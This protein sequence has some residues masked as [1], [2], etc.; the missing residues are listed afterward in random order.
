MKTVDGLIN[1]GKLFLFQ[2][3]TK[4]YSEKS[5]GKKNLHTMYWEAAF[6]P[7]NIKDV[8]VKINGEAE[9]FFRHKSRELKVVTHRAGSPLVNRTDKD[10]KPI[11]SEIYYELFRFKTGQKKYDDLSPEVRSYIDKAVVSEAKYDI[12]KDRRYTEDRMFFHIPLTFNFKASGR[13]NIND[14]AIRYYL[15]NPDVHIMGIDRG[16]RN[17]IYYSIIDRDGKIVRDENGKCLQGNFNIINGIDYHQKLDIRQK[18]RQESRRNWKVVEKIKDLKEGYISLVVHEIAEM[19]VKY[20]AV[21]VMED[22]NFGFKRGRFKFEKQVYQKFEQML[23]DKLNYLVFKEAGLN[24]IGGVMKAYQFTDKFDSFQK[25]GKQSGILF[26]VPASYTSKIDP[27]TGFTDLFNMA[28]ITSGKTR[29]DFVSKMESVVYNPVDNGFDITFDYRDFLTTQTDHRNKWT[30]STRGTRIKYDSKEKK[31]YVVDPTAELCES[32][33]KAGIIYDAEADILQKILKSNDQGL[34][35][36][37]FYSFKNS[38]I[39]IRNMSKFLMCLFKTIY[40]NRYCRQF[41]FL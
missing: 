14:M 17:L 12:V 36:T 31:H 27:M 10:G 38:F 19:I 3:Y 28:S 15:D 7:E 11:P 30:V 16:E 20:N 2:L 24:D 32:L 26:Y 35:D 18:E 40:T 22:L 9:L 25:L 6:S 1:E 13:Q 37:V 5:R 39:R 33:T 4:D 29:M 34:I 21:V 41:S 8:V 23:I